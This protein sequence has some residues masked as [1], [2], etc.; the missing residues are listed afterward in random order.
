MGESWVTV[1][2]TSFYFAVFKLK[3]NDLWGAIHLP[4]VRVWVA[5]NY[6][7]HN[8]TF[9]FC[10]I[11]D[12]IFTTFDR[13]DLIKFRFYIHTSSGEYFTIFALIHPG[14]GVVAGHLS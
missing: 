4:S 12:V 1:V 14:H 10:D 5:F 9:S 11:S 6:F 8:Y 13:V 2:A 3:N 7:K